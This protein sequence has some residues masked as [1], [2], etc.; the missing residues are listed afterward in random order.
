M[1][2]ERTLNRVEH[3]AK[4]S[5]ECAVQRYCHHPMGEGLSS[6]MSLKSFVLFVCFLARCS[7]A[8]WPRSW[9]PC[10][11]SRAS[12]PS[13][14]DPRHRAARQAGAAGDTPFRAPPFRCYGRH[15]RAPERH[16]SRP[17]ARH[18]GTAYSTRPSR[19]EARSGLLAKAPE[20][21]ATSRSTSIIFGA[22]R[23]GVCPGSGNSR[24]R[25]YGSFT[26]WSRTKPDGSPSSS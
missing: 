15:T 23:L 5:S 22:G 8:M 25:R 10:R 4:Q 14:S 26:T 3:E 21:P 18:P 20:G 19:P 17:R 11:S 7:A 13:P 16:R 2:L 24:S 12:S 1:A 9:A 6:L